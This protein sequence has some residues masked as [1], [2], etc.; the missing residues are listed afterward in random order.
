MLHCAAGASAH[1]LDNEAYTC[2]VRER[3]LGARRAPLRAAPGLAKEGEGRNWS[4]A[5]HRR[6]ALRARQEVPQGQL[7]AEG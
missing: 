6:H 1:S 3:A 2:A 4:G 7:A 5:A